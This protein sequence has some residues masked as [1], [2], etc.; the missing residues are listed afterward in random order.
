[1]CSIHPCIFCVGLTVPQS[2]MLQHVYKNVYK[3]GAIK[4]S[5][6]DE[7]SYFANGTL[8]RVESV[9]GRKVVYQWD[10]EVLQPLRGRSDEEPPSFGVGR[11]NGVWLSWYRQDFLLEEPLMR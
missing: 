6:E 3:G 2:E 9:S 11:W 7:W 8:E 4:S 1:M 5:Y 10:G